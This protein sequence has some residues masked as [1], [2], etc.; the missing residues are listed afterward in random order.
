VL[1]I[2]QRVKIVEERMADHSELFKDIRQ[3]LLQFE[4]RVDRRFE[5]IEGRLTALDQKFDALGHSLGAELVAQR[6]DMNAQFRWTSGIMLTGLVAIV[7][8]ILAG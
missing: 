2:E 6:R 8:A 7:A 1:S 3:G 5:L 4:A